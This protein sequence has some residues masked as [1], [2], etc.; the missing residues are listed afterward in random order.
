MPT[1]LDE[2]AA[3]ALALPSRDGEAAYTAPAELAA[4]LTAAI[5]PVQ[6]PPAVARRDAR[7]DGDYWPA[8]QRADAPRRRPVSAS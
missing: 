5:P 7:R 3:R 1:I 8:E 4:A 6:V 2:V